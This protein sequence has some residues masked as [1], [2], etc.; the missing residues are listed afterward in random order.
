[1]LRPIQPFFQVIRVGRA[2]P[3]IGGRKG[4]AVFIISSKS[5][6]PL[7]CLQ[8]Q[9]SKAV[10]FAHQGAVEISSKSIAKSVKSK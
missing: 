2:E 1:M 8:Q 3:P 9:E 7:L 10:F 6:R 5:E 4:G